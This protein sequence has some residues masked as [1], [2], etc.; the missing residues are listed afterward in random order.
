MLHVSA[1]L[2][3]VERLTLLFPRSFSLTKQDPAIPSSSQKQL[4]AELKAETQNAAQTG[5]CNHD[6]KPRQCS[7]F[8][9]S[10]QLHKSSC[11]CN[12]CS[13]HSGPPWPKEQLSSS[14]KVQAR[15]SPSSLELLP[16]GP[17]QENAAAPALLHLPCDCHCTHSL[18]SQCI[19]L[20]LMKPLCPF[21]KCP[22]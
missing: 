6:E 10:S 13:Q 7:G 18:P 11:S 15:A 4:P 2:T 21:L 1:V 16:P 19:I 22:V 9:A 20:V 8:P 3:A 12:T 14:W 17:S 5:K